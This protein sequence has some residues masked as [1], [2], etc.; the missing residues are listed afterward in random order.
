MPATMLNF[1]LP[2]Q[3]LAAG[4]QTGVP[5]IAEIVDATGAGNFPY[6]FVEIRVAP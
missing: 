4:G 2:W 3:G 5:Y 1:D 6:E